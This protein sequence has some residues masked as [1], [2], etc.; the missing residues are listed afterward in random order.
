MTYIRY[1]WFVANLHHGV[2]VVRLAK[3]VPAQDQE[4][5][6]EDP[7]D[8]LEEVLHTDPLCFEVSLNLIKL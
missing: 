6:E 4:E 2:H 1:C 8:F 3:T 7:V 5:H